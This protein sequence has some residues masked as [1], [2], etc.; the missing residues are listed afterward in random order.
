MKT[1]HEK[2]ADI[3]GELGKKDGIVKVDITINAQA[4]RYHHSKSKIRMSPGK[5]AM[6]SIKNSTLDETKAFIKDIYASIKPPQN[7]YDFT[8]HC[9]VYEQTGHGEYVTG[10]LLFMFTTKNVNNS[11]YLFDHYEVKDVHRA[12]K[13]KVADKLKD[14]VKDVKDLF[15]SLMGKK[16]VAGQ[17]KQ[18]YRYLV[19]PVLQAIAKRL[20]ATKESSDAVKKGFLYLYKQG[21]SVPEILNIFVQQ[22]RF[23]FYR[24]NADERVDTVCMDVPGEQANN[25]KACYAFVQL[26]GEDNRAT[27]KDLEGTYLPVHPSK[28]E[29]GSNPHLAALLATKLFNRYVDIMFSSMK[30]PKKSASK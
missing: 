5:H 30:T 21:V 19:H 1:I 22:N 6:F 12:V 28:E 14:L 3:N 23:C 10:N 20:P 29:M 25:L 15:D 11:S 4:I 16:K 8:M 9:N 2:V 24:L 26:F 13:G 17:H 18:D 7:D 27:L